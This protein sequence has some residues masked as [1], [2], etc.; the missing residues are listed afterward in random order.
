VTSW[1][2][3][4]T[5]FTDPSP[6]LIQ[7]LRSIQ[8]GWLPDGT[9]SYDHT[10]DV[11]EF[12]IVGN[13]LSSGEFLPLLPESLNK[14]APFDEVDAYPDDYLRRENAPVLR[15][16][17]YKVSPRV[18][19]EL[20]N[21]SLLPTDRS[22]LSRALQLEELLVEQ[23][24]DLK[25]Q[26]AMAITGQATIF[27]VNPSGLIIRTAPIDGVQQILVPASLRPRLLHLEHFPRTAGHP[28]VTQMYRSL[29][30]RYLWQKMS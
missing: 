27:D 20:F 1:P 25:C 28:G 30:R 13:V 19:G 21:T 29:R 18:E 17:I 24:T 15:R 4:S 22:P 12:G 10:T 6:F 26:A 3:K 16:G 8:H 14:S 7:D 23:A 9:R 11:D 5:L 2:D